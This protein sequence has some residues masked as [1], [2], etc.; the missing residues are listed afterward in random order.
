MSHYKS[1]LIAVDVSPQASEVVDRARSVAARHASFHLV[2][3]VE[4]IIA[5]TDMNLTPVISVEVEQAMV[6]RAE[7]YLDQLIHDAGLKG[8][9]REVL[10]GGVRRSI[11]QLAEDKDADLIVIG[12][13]GRHGLG[14]LLGS[15]ANAVLHGAGCDILAVHI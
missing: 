4:P 2:H 1:I 15:T 13:H 14:L 7:N 3:V 5:E 8:A 6:E 9:S 10:M 11:H 12:S